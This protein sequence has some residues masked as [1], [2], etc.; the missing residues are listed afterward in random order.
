MKNNSKKALV[1]KFSE[2]ASRINGLS[3]PVFGISW[4]PPEPER[5]IIRSILIFLEDRRALYN[6]N[7]FEMEHQVAQSV[8]EIRTTLTDALQRLSES[9]NALSNIRSMRIACR[10][11]LDASHD[12]RHSGFLADLGRLR[13]IFGYHITQLAVMYGIDI[14]GELVKILPPEYKEET[15]LDKDLY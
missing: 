5:K 4:Q 3:I 2:L 15:S 11:Y 9:S 10:E 6:P 1:Y 14:E 8:L 7:A 12:S 13:T